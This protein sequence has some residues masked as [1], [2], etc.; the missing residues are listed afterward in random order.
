MRENEEKK[1]Q[2]GGVSYLKDERKKEEL[3]SILS[4]LLLREQY[5]GRS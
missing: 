4:L 3:I 2:G 5:A 1:G